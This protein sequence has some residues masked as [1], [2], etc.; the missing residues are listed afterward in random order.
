MYGKNFSRYFEGLFVAGCK[1]FY[2]IYGYTFHLV[3][4]SSPKKLMRISIFFFIQILIT[5]KKFYPF[6]SK[7]SI[8]YQFL[9]HE[10][11]KKYVSI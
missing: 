9:M 11:R 5:Q 3:A 6:V 7:S 4:Y 10:Y 2:K 1:Y 8:F